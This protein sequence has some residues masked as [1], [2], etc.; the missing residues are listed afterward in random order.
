MTQAF[1]RSASQARIVP[2]QQQEPDYWGPF[3]R[4]FNASLKESPYEMEVDSGN[5]TSDPEGQQHL[6]RITKE[7]QTPHFEGDD[8]AQSWNQPVKETHTDTVG[9]EDEMEVEEYNQDWDYAEKEPADPALPLHPRGLLGP[10]TGPVARTVRPVSQTAQQLANA[11]GLPVAPQTHFSFAKV[12]LTELNLPAGS[13][14]TIKH[15]LMAGIFDE[16]GRTLAK[17]KFGTAKV[18]EITSEAAALHPFMGVGDPLWDAFMASIHKAHPVILESEETGLSSL[19]PLLQQVVNNIESL[20][21]A[22]ETVEP[23]PVVSSADSASLYDTATA[24]QLVQGTQSRACDMEASYKKSAASGFEKL[25]G[26]IG[27]VLKHPKLEAAIRTQQNGTQGLRQM[28]EHAADFESSFPLIID[29]LRRI[30]SAWVNMARMYI[31][32]D[33]MSLQPASNMTRYQYFCALKVIEKT[34]IEAVL[35][36]MFLER[37]HDWKQK[38][39]PSFA[40][41][42]GDAAAWWAV[43]QEIHDPMLEI[44]Q[45]GRDHPASSLPTGVEL[46]TNLSLDGLVCQPASRCT[47]GASDEF[48]TDQAAS[49]DVS[50]QVTSLDAAAPPLP[51]DFL[52]GLDDLEAES[53]EYFRAVN[54]A[55][56]DSGHDS[57]LIDYSGG[58]EA[59]IC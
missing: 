5:R 34:V 2:K 10:E 41:F 28:P 45:L 30:I 54:T 56:P 57:D 51:P 13:L 53:E 11:A 9:I 12:V 55:L 48:A 19:S 27:Q 26:A 49:A 31:V 21:Q 58:E 47:N 38:Y 35:P 46:E 24:T 20:R 14:D 43:M 6:D 3:L 16:L 50:P 17:A 15:M 42:D 59:N 7:M 32:Q 44:F 23:P 40:Y 39:L 4:A 18:E 25:K 36:Y 33:K 8:G 52:G 1:R 37:L 22:L 29:R